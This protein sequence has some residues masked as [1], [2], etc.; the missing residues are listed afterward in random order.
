MWA[1]FAYRAHPPDF[2][3]IPPSGPPPTSDDIYAQMIY[4]A[5]VQLRVLIW[6]TIALVKPYFAADIFRHVLVI[7]FAFWVTFQ[8]ASIYLDDIFELDD[9]S[10]AARFIRVAAFVGRYHRVH[11][12]DGGISP[13]N[14][15]SPVFRI[16]GPG[17]VL[18]HLENA[19]LFEDIHGNPRVILPEDRYTQLE[20]FE[21]LRTIVDLRDQFLDSQPVPGRTKDG[22]QVTAKD[23]KVVFSVH[24]GTPPNQEPASSSSAQNGSDKDEKQEQKSL[25]YDR[26]ALEDA[27]KNLTY[28]Q[29]KRAWSASAKQNILPKLRAFIGQHTL[30]EF[31]ANVNP[32]ELAAIRQKMQ[33]QSPSGQ[34]GSPTLDPSM[35]SEFMARIEITQSVQGKPEDGRGRGFDV[36]WVGVGTWETPEV[37]PK[38]HIEA[39]ELTAQ[40]RVDGSEYALAKLQR[41]SR[42]EELR[43]LIQDVPIQAFGLLLR[44]EDP[45]PKNVKYRLARA[46]REK[47]NNA[48]DIYLRNEQT[49][50]TELIR[51]IE[52]LSNF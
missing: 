4:T 26:E 48:R 13:K 20:G 43:R 32:E 9:T 1:I 22:I 21:R 44:G 40:N 23:V 52:H 41:E 5:I 28:K 47:L 29:I 33:S 25:Y 49:P 7:G 50:P 31:L 12:I 6:G 51:T 14:K 37:I 36:H 24:R 34:A 15:D 30:D 38:H 46:Y 8:I 39:W 45:K 27:I 18:V 10:I 2:S 35:L 17:K 11:I 19:A 42:S 3:I 16:G